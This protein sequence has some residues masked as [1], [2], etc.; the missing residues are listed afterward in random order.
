MSLFGARAAGCRLT[1]ATQAWAVAE[2]PATAAARIVG[3]RMAEQLQITW[4]AAEMG[5]EE[6]EC[7]QQHQKVNKRNRKKR[8][9]RKAKDEARINDKHA[10][11][12][13]FIS[14]LRVQQ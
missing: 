4:P 9:E 5:R 2:S 14:K 12:L 8:T 1:A 3:M 13:D 11:A 10:D 6:L 7:S